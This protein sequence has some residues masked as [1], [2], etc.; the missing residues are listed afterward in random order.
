MNHF[1]IKPKR[2]R[3]ANRDNYYLVDSEGYIGCVKE[4]RDSTDDARYDY[5]NYFK[6]R[7]EAELVAK[8]MRDLFK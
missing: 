7:E 8:K 3:A 1:I 4:Y 5:G 2:W 6:T